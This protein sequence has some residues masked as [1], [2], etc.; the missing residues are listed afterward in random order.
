MAF[1]ALGTE[2]VPVSTTQ[3]ITESFI[4]T[5][6]SYSPY[7]ETNIVTY[8]SMTVWSDVWGYEVPAGYCYGVGASYCTTYSWEPT[9]TIYNTEFLPALTTYEIPMSSTIPYYATR[10]QSITESSTNNVSASEVLGLSDGIFT[11]LAIGVIAFLVVVTAWSLF[12]RGPEQTTL[13]QYIKLPIT[14][15]KCGAELPSGSI[16][17]NKCGAKQG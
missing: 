2:T 4:E 11:G 15:V 16:F 6:T 13:S 10:N 7:T 12:R 3:T 5:G 17:C 9:D 8:T 14:C 1:L